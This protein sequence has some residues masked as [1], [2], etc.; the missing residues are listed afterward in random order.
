MNRSV[1]MLANVVT[2]NRLHARFVRCQAIV[3]QISGFMSTSPSSEDLQEEWNAD[4]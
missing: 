1:P 4:P 2:D 3:S